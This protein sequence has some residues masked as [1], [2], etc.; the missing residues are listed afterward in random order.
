MKIDFKVGILDFSR[1]PPSTE[2]EMFLGFET[3]PYFL[4]Q[5]SGCRLKG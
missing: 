2:P 4:N 1:L 3:D 5:K